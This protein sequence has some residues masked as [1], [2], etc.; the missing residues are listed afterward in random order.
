MKLY[1]LSEGDVKESNKRLSERDMENLDANALR[2]ELCRLYEIYGKATSKKDKDDAAENIR[3]FKVNKEFDK[4]L[5]DV[6]DKNKDNKDFIDAM[7]KEAHR[8]DNLALWTLQY[9]MSRH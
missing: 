1:M 4:V 3:A 7:K 2:K 5:G 9:L 6:L 8:G